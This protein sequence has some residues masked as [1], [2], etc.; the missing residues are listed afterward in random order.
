[1][2]ARARNREAARKASTA[3]VKTKAALPIGARFGKMLRARWQWVLATIVVVHVVLA[4]MVIEPAP[5]T[6]GDNAGYLTLA[7]SLLERHEYRDLY[8]STEPIHTQYPPVFPAILAVA[9]TLGIKPWFQIKLLIIAFS[10][11][12]VAFS[13][14]WL[15]RHG[16][17]EL[18]TGVA[19][20]L[21]VSPGVLAQAHWELS[22]V[23]FWALTMIA[24]WAWQRVPNGLRARFFVAVA[25]T[26]LAYF[27]RSAGLPLL[28]AAGGW[29]AWRKRWQQLAIFAAVILP[30]AFLWWLRA[31]SQGGVDYVSQF[32]SLDPYNP[33]AGR[34]HI[35]DLFAR[36]AD[37]GGRYLNRH[38]PM[39]LFGR[40]G[41]LP[42][43]VIITALGFYG[44]LVRMRRPSVS[45]LFLP[46]YIGLLL[47]WPAVWS[48]E[49]FLLPAL[50][51]LL[52]YA[53]DA[54]VRLTWMV[55]R[56]AARI[57]AAVAVALVVVFGLPATS[58]AMRIG[59][60][61]T[62]LYRGGDTYACLP[63]AYKDFY[64]IAEISKRVLPDKAAVLSRKARSFYIIGGLAGRQYPLSDDPARFFS[65][66]TAAH[67][68]YVVYDQLDGLANAYLAPVL[69]KK[70][71]AF[72]MMFSHGPEKPA[73]FGID[74]AAAA[75]PQPQPGDG[76]FKQCGVE[77]WR[78]AAVRDSMMAGQIP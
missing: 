62:A 25:M 33:A 35:T 21:A 66:A 61:C 60:E 64:H 54:I 43:S 24:V 23:P 56:N 19:A 39:L 30:L 46:L 1:M 76:S 49:R 16:R 74:L 28:I 2:A 78:S 70:S 59:K 40:E 18:A 67:A 65:E 10:A 32:W 48:G 12:A 31:K 15:R 8:D 27:T 34:I 17:P 20:V 3:R 26:T 22:D 38:L 13:F 58:Q 44:W 14:L 41:L 29:L 37:N 77:Y 7:H 5:H 6:G 73:L 42:L 47:V 50:P 51:F 52:F 55:S 72:C 69:L 68:R 11:L 9:L 63:D 4:V 71:N 75:T 36:A 57:P 53:G 45:E